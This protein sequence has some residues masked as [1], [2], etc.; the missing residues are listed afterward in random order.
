MFWK[1]IRHSLCCIWARFTHKCTR[2]KTNAVLDTAVIQIFGQKIKICREIPAN[3]P[4]YE[5]TV[6]VP[7]AELRTDPK[8]GAREIILNSIT[9]AHSPRLEGKTGPAKITIP[10]S[11]RLDNGEL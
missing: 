6:V 3:S 9:I 8:T 7:R 10:R 4:P 5:L 11:D 2:L 1:K